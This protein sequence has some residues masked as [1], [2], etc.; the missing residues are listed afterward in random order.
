MNGTHGDGGEIS[1]SSCEAAEWPSKSRKSNPPSTPSLSGRGVSRAALV[2][3]LLAALSLCAR[4]AAQEPSTEEL[5][6]LKAHVI[7]VKSVNAGTG[8]DDLRPLKDLI[9][10]ARIVA[11]GEGTHGTRE[12]FQMKHR[13]VEY[14]AT[15]L[16]FTIFAIEANM[17]EAYRVNDFVRTGQGEPRQLL[18][19]MYFWTWN[20][21]EVLDLILWMRAFNES[22]RGRIEFTGFDMQTPDLAMQIAREYVARV[23]PAYAP[24]VTTAYADAKKSGPAGG[25]T[26]FGVATGSFPVAAAAGKRVQYSGYIKTQGITRGWAGLWWRVDGESGVLAFD[27]M[28]G[29]GAT[30]TADW[31]RYEIELPVAADA[32]N[33][34]FGA[35]LTGDGSAWFDELRVELN[36][37]PYAAGAPA[38]FDFESGKLAGFMTGGDGYRVEVD[39]ETAKSGRCSLKITYA[40][41]EKGS[42]IDAKGA[43]KLCRAI[44]EHLDEHR[45]DYE[46]ASSAKEFAW[47]RQNAR[48]VQQCYEMFGNEVPRDLSMARNVRWILEQAPPDAKIVLWAHN[49]HVSADRPGFGM[50]PMGASLREWYGDKYVVLGFA[51][52]TGRYT[53][54]TKGEGLSSD[55]ELQAATP[56]CAEYAFHALGVPRFILDLR[57]AK[58]DDPAAAWLTRPVKFRSIG[59]LAMDEQFF[60]LALPRAFDALIYID[61]TTPTKTLR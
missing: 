12:F 40:S 6:W 4:A 9:G 23:E 20:T 17:P 49:G 52:N 48:V 39:G 8:F 56:G 61:A 58:A 16:A 2:A 33:I 45:A 47:A 13:L 25:A 18:A 29:R 46:A 31:Q 19:G 60:P 7:E 32:R 57:Q 26:G 54:I 37:E 30:G 35:I 27:N 15:E 1:L 53:A 42:Q 55:N 11:L 44:V 24:S 41:Q 59:A 36:G 43:A 34:N 38:D 51:A 5:A 50:G 22:G 3:V 28:N 14:L 10:P 21:Q